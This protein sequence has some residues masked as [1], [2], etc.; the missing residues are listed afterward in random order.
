MFLLLLLLLLFV[1]LFMSHSLDVP[2]EGLRIETIVAHIPGTESVCP[3][4]LQF[5]EKIEFSSFL[6]TFFV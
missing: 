1:Q 2:Q 5:E 4:P 6:C 3:L